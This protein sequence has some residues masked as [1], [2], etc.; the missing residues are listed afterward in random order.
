MKVVIVTMEN[1]YCGYNTAITLK[2]KPNYIF[3]QSISMYDHTTAKI[4]N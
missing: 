3:L 1:Y 2:F 4:D